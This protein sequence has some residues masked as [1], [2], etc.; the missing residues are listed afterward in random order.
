MLESLFFRCC[1]PYSRSGTKTSGDRS[2]VGRVPDCDSGCRGF[3]P[4]RSPQ[5]SLDKSSNYAAPASGVFCSCSEF[6]QNLTVLACAAKWLGAKCAYFCTISIR[7]LPP[8]SFS[9]ING[10]PACTCHD[11]KVCRK[12]CHLKSDTPAALHARGNALRSCLLI[13]LPSPASSVSGTALALANL[14][15]SCDTANSDETYAPASLLVLAQTS[16]A[17]DP[18]DEDSCYVVSGEDSIGLCG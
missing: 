17:E 9:T 10:V 18:I 4:H 5:N 3:E 7:S 6:D 2:S 1:R 16:N 13:R 14:A 11:A 15:S 12:S 8:S